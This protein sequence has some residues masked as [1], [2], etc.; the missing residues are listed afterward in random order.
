MVIRFALPNILFHIMEDHFG[1]VVGKVE[2]GG[3][4]LSNSISSIN[5]NSTVLHAYTFI[6]T[7]CYVAAF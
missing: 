4:L 6:Y 5:Y 7:R 1:F 3:F 2:I